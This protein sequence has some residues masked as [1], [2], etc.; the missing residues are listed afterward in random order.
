MENI[1][2]LV[3]LIMLG[4]TIV[5]GIIF[6]LL[7]IKKAHHTNAQ[8]WAIVKGVLDILNGLPAQIREE[9]VLTRELINLKSPEEF[10]AA[11]AKQAEKLQKQ[12]D[13][14]GVIVTEHPIDPIEKVPFVT[15]NGVIAPD[16]ETQ[17]A[18]AWAIFNEQ[19]NKQT[20]PVTD[21]QCYAACRDSGVLKEVVDNELPKWRQFHDVPAPKP[22]SKKSSKKKPV[23]KKK[24]AKKKV[25]AKPKK[26]GAVQAAK[27]FTVAEYDII[28]LAYAK[29]IEEGTSQASLIRELN[30]KLGRNHTVK[31]YRKVW[32]GE[33]DKDTLSE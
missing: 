28:V 13:S 5:T 10:Y 25:A 24:P 23:A 7:E 9:F 19:A 26:T 2:L 27:P 15:R 33:I 3:G 20:S 22:K 11:L 29:H 30:E 18:Y 1:P 6:L 31:V 12:K 14:S 17:A 16:A 8:S 32:L 4:I 21:K